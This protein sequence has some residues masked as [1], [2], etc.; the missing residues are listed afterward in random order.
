MPPEDE[1]REAH[2][3]W[4]NLLGVRAENLQK[5]GRLADALAFAEQSVE[6][7]RRYYS[8]SPSEEQVR[9]MA[10][11]TGFRDRIAEELASSN[12]LAE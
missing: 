1:S 8:S 11:I 4:A 9:A 12:N 2:Y 10:E 3:L 5:R 6:S 7:H